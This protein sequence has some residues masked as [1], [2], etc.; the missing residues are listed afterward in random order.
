MN[1]D[2]YTEI[3]TPADGDT[4]LNHDISETVVGQKM[5]RITWANIKATLKTYFDTLYPS[6]DGWS[7]ISG[8]FTYASATTINVSSGAASL[9]SVGD[10]IRFKQ[11]AGYKYFY[12]VGVADTVLTV[13]GGSDYTV[14]TPTAITDIYYS[15]QE[16]PL[17]FPAYFNWSPTWS[18]GITIG[19]ATIV[20]KFKLIGK[21]VFVI[22]RVV[23]GNTSSIS[24]HVTL[25]APL[26]INT[27]TLFPVN[28]E[29]SG[30][31]T[32]FG[33]AAFNAGNPI[34]VFQ[35]KTDETYYT[36]VLFSSTVPFTWT[37][38]D[39]FSFMG[40]YDIA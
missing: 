29:D 25:T 12:I 1:W 5:K 21:T 15:H 13:T 8:T 7:P 3:T 30:T 6:K 39:S 24:G 14:A 18:A 26:T 11:G 22:V 38:S 16:N 40:S 34:A 35:G 10:K 32:F 2:D 23:L 20:T 17:G 33:N 19:N 27:T 36:Y 4:F 28:I 37:T 9:Y 31:T